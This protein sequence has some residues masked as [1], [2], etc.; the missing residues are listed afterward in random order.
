M[1][2]PF[3]PKVEIMQVIHGPFEDDEGR[4]WN[5]CLARHCSTNE[6]FEEEYYYQSLKDAMDDVS[7]LHKTGPFLIDDLGNTEQDH[8]DKQTRKVIE[9][10]Q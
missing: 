9:Y 3:E 6:P 5:L 1:S 4:V 7:R 8:S 2:E 10:V